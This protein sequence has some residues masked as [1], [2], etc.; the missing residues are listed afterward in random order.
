MPS[1]GPAAGS[2]PARRSPSGAVVDAFSAAV[3]RVAD[4]SIFSRRRS[5]FLPASACGRG[6][7]RRRGPRAQPAARADHGREQAGVVAADAER[8]QRGVRR[9]RGELRRLDAGRRR[10]GPTKASVVAPEQLTSTNV[11]PSSAR[12]QAGVVAV[13]PQAARLLLGLRHPGRRGVGVA[14][15]DV[16]GVRR[17]LASWAAA[18][19]RVADGG[20]GGPSSHPA[21]AATATTARAATDAAQ[22]HARPRYGGAPS[23][24]VRPSAAAPRGPGRPRRPGPLTNGWYGAA[25][26][27]RS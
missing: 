21:S 26:P 16:R 4:L 12:E 25:T 8:D 3:T 17:A 1:P 6:R 24:C 19:G 20:R 14:Q 10:A 23:H 27:G 22:R 2:R 15:R 9:E 7:G 5:F 18:G 11:D 13:R